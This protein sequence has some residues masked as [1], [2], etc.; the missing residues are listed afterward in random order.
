M[1]WAEWKCRVLNQICSCGGRHTDAEIGSVGPLPSSRMCWRMWMGNLTMIS[2]KSR[3]RQL[4]V[5]C[6]DIWH[7]E[8]RNADVQGATQSSVAP[9]PFPAAGGLRKEDVLAHVGGDFD[10]ETSAEEMAEN[11]ALADRHAELLMSQGYRMVNI[12]LSGHA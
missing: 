11:A 12:L 4:R 3:W 5:C 1:K 10:D 9:V 2:L 8:W 6:N 7:A